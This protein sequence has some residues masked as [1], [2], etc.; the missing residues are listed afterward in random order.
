MPLQ[1][2]WPAGRG[3]SAGLGEGTGLLEGAGPVGRAGSEGEGKQVEG[4]WSVEREGVRL[5]P[6]RQRAA[7]TVPAQR[8][9]QLEGA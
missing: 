5:S 2:V 4:A 8:W 1:G 6:R 9:N 3:G 7:E